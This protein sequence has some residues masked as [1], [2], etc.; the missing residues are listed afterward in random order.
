MKSEKETNYVTYHHNWYDHSDSRHPRIRTC[1]VHSYNNYFDGNAKYGI[2]VTM[3]ASAFAENNY[4]RNCKNPM[5]SSGQ[6]TDALGEGTFSGETGGI[7][8]AC[9][10]YIEGASSYIPYSQD[11]TSFDAYEVSSPTEKVPDSVKTVSG[12]TGYNNFDTDSSIMYSYQAD[13]A[14]D[15]PAIV[16]AK[17]GRVQGGDFQ[18]KFNNSVDDA[19]YA[20]NQ[21]LKDALMNYTPVS[22]TH[23][24]LPTIA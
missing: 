14:K 1:S 9:G 16:T 6:G 13:D 12:G 20:V 18:W 3:G 21:P 8:K 4:F 10:N 19:S 17:A 2:G 7:I 15:V 11:S 5:M 24:T 23:L 22:Y